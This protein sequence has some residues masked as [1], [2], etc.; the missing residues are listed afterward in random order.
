MKYILTLI[1]LL[2]ALQIGIIHGR[3]LERE[4]TLAEE[5]SD[6]YNCQINHDCDVAE[7][8]K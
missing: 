8:T 3:Q 1:A 5:G 6:M 2:G 7:V 4:E